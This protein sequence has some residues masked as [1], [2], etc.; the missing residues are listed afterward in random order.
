MSLLP[1]YRV[2]TTV[3]GPVIDL[4]LNKRLKRG[5]EDP[6]RLCERRGQGTLPRPEGPL[7]WLH[8]ASVGEAVSSIALIEQLLAAHPALHV[9][10]TTGTVTSARLMA[11]RLPQ[12]VLHQFVPVDRPSWVGRFLDHWRPDG[13]IWLES[14]LW[15]NLVSMA[16][17]RGVPMAMV[18][19]RMSNRSFER[20]QRLPGGIAR[21]LDCFKLC[22]VQTSEDEKRYR[23][24]QAPDVR[25]LGNLK[26]VAP[27]LPVDAARLAGLQP[28][29]AGRPNW[30]AASTHPGEEEMVADCHQSLAERHPGLLTLLVPRHPNRADEVAE[31]LAARGLKIQ[32]RSIAPEAPIAPD[33]EIYLADTLGEMG[34]FYR[35]S[36]IVLVGGS[37]TGGVGGHNPMEPA[38]LSSALLHGPDMQ[39]FSDF[40][41]ELHA[42][43]AAEEVV[44]ADELAQ[45]V[46][47]LLKDDD[48]RRTRIEAAARFA[49]QGQQVLE[50]IHGALREVMPVLQSS[51]AGS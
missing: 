18:N 38:Q 11:E 36:E 39:N 49:G 26:A 30:I 8:A 1:L 35:L 44:N 28:S 21:L 16:A 50:D 9:L 22:L 46:S 32:R 25:N 31:M 24:L 10:Q 4:Y 17:D 47:R 19:A 3:A 42:L 14:E 40:S 2:A 33:C 41:R 7:V 27:V 34:L 29:V 5:K 45:A 12:R 48:L 20:W 15:P 6:L 51:G 43:G 23:A 37:L 13:G